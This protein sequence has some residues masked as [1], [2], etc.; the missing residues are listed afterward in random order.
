MSLLQ[1][2][3]IL[4]QMLLC[5][6]LLLGGLLLY[7]IF[8]VSRAVNLLEILTSGARDHSMLQVWERH[9]LPGH[10]GRFLF[11]FWRLLLLVDGIKHQMFHN[12]I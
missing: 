6:L 5:I 10:R 4:L 11:Q 2:L 9:D 8:Q 7:G 1:A 3:V 12:F